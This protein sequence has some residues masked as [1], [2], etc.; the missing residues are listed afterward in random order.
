MQYDIYI[1]VVRQQRVKQVTFNTCL[2]LQF[3]TDVYTIR[4][5]KYNVMALRHNKSFLTTT[6]TR[7]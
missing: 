5:F 3:K 1:Y 2:Y 6:Y 7:Q 4:T